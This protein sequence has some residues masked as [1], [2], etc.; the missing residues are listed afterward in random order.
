MPRKTPEQLTASILR[1]RGSWPSP[2]R[3]LGRRG[4]EIWRQVTQVR[5]PDYFAAHLHQLQLYC[6]LTASAEQVATALVRARPGS[7]RS[8]VLRDDLK[9]LTPIVSRLGR[10]LR[11]HVNS[12]L[13]HNDGRVDERVGNVVALDGLLGGHA[14]RR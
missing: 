12:K 9:S 5:A 3:G 4:C 8:T 7:A 1:T 14:I 11:L 10:E 13:R 2:P 6:L